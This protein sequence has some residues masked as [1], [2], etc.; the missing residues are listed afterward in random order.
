LKTFFLIFIIL[1]TFIS[2]FSSLIVPLHAETVAKEHG[3]NDYSNLGNI[4]IDSG[5]R[6]DS[7]PIGVAVNPSTNKIYVANE[8]SNTVS[9]IDGSTDKVDATIKVGKS[10]YGIGVNPLNNRIY[11]SN[12]DSDTV[13]VID[14][15]TK[16]QIT[17]V[18]AGNRPIGVAVNPSNSLIYVTN[19]ESNAVSI[20]DGITN[21]F[22]GTIK[23]GNAPY[24]V[25]VDP[26]NNKTYVTNVLDNTISV[27]HGTKPTDNK[28]VKTIKVI[29]GI[30]PAGIAINTSTNR[31]YVTNYH[32]G[33]LF[34]IDTSADK[35]VNSIK[36]G[37]YPVGVE[38]NPINDKIY[39]T[40]IGDNTVSVI[41]G[42]KNQIISTITV[43]PILKPYFKDNDPL[44]NIPVGVGFPSITSFVSIDSA[45]NMVYVTNT[46]SNTISKINGDK[47]AVAVRLNF[48][49]NPPNS[50]DIECNGVKNF[51]GNS[52]LYTRGQIIQCI[53][54][55]NRAYS[56]DSWS[57]IVNNVSNPLTVRI[58]EFGTLTASFVPTFPPETYLFIILGIV[59]SVPIFLGWLNRERQR[60]RLT[61]YLTRIET[62]HDRLFEGNKQD[63]VLQLQQISKEILDLFKR[64]KISDSYYNILDRKATDYISLAYRSERNT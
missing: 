31:M 18:S 23:V 41:D 44:V 57:S 34:I 53:A 59:G 19:F 14:G 2:Q 20:I 1:I 26:L 50:G 56:F 4:K 21:T 63:Y 22:S 58:S 48:N 60:R 39:V 28:V 37:R 8:F 24:G 46:A 7:Y 47:D 33:S 54:H 27:I 32:S 49:I 64:G 6:V 5:I 36:V 35:L 10:P 12:R 30:S 61:R 40:N 15:S 13:S 38:V 11:V 45:T 52:T 9:I 17:N 51:A 16:S 25:A 29:G 43:N 3:A 42:K 55:P 62:T